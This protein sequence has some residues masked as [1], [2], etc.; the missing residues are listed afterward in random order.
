M[1]L[2]K[3]GVA[4]ALG[5]MCGAFISRGFQRCHHHEAVK[6]WACARQLLERKNAS[7]Q[8]EIGLNPTPEKA[9]ADINKISDGTTM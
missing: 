6:R 1:A 7:T 5:A 4:F 8:Q 2:V 3:T 9:A